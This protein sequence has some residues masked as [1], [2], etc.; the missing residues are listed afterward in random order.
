MYTKQSYLTSSN[1]LAD[2]V[3]GVA[4]ARLFTTTFETLD[5]GA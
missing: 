3:V 4:F 2:M 5:T 1:T